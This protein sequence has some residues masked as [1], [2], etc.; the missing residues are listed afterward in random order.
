MR[1]LDEGVDVPQVSEVFILASNTV[2]RQWVQR[3]GR[4]LRKCDAIN[5]EIAHLHDFIV[6]PPD[7]RDSGSRTILKGELERA[8]EFAELAANSGNA[9]RSVRRNRETNERNV[10]LA[11]RRNG[12][13]AAPQIQA[14]AVIR[15][16]VMLVE[17][18]YD[19]YQRDLTATLHDLL[20]L[21]SDRPFNI[22]QQISRRIT[23]LGERLVQK[24]G[25][26]E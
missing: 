23:A 2:R 13:S 22:A 5:K 8:R 25:D 1:V 9:R 18:R 3:R 7:P 20:L 11:K 19:G 15:T 6:V 4:V 14:L 10:R 26:T 24:G 16:K 12:M 17:E 21:E